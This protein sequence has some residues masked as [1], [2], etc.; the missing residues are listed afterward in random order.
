MAI[1]A[2]HFVTKMAFIFS[3]ANSVTESQ[4]GWSWK[5]LLQA[6]KSNPPAQAV[7]ARAGCPDYVLMACEDLQA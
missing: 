2:T 6:T 7:P 3:I 4:N 5:G 1:W